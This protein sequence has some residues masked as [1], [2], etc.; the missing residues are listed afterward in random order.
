VH[1]K[2]QVAR[3][4]QDQR[5]KFKLGNN[6]NLIWTKVMLLSGVSE[7]ILKKIEDSGDTE[8]KDSWSEI[9]ISDNQNRIAPL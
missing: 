6:F 4:V 9:K 8:R 1:E 7:E 5:E 2:E 3:R